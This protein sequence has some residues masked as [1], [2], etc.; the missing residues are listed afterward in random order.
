MGVK[1]A[2]YFGQRTDVQVPVIE[3]IAECD[4]IRN[5]PFMN[6]PCGKIRKGLK[7]VC[8]VRKRNGD[9]WI[10]CRE[11]LCS[12]NKD[13]PLT[14]YQKSTLLAI[15]REVFSTDIERENVLIKRE[16]SMPVVESSYH[17][18]YIMSI[19]NF[20]KNLHGPNNV[21]LEMQGGGETSNTGKITSHVTQWERAQG[22]T[23]KFL[24][25]E[26]GQAGTIETN[27]WRRQQEQ[28]IVKGNISSQTGGGI[29][30]CVGSLLYDYLWQRM[31]E[32]NLRNLREHNWS[33]C[34]L[35][36]EEDKAG[37]PAPGPIPLRINQE[38]IIFTNYITFVQA[39]INQ[40]QPYPAMFT[41]TFE[42]LEGTLIDIAE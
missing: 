26:I 20:Q 38:K 41:G 30:F 33:M 6:K 11:R 29:V 10:V 16:T 7:P 12:T 31:R 5:C 32:V 34:L 4:A 36:F 18:D 42:T 24:M 25:A 3:P 28:F 9:V 2:E 39:L 40:G 17:A 35:C 27:A 19:R 8:S 13:V 22:R 1:I 37:A 23:N 21:V 14:E 15:A